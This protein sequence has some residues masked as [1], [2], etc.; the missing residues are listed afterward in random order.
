MYFCKFSTKTFGWYSW[1]NTK[2]KEGVNVGIA[3][4]KYT[5]LIRFSVNHV[6]LLYRFQ[7]YSGLP[8]H[9]FSVCLL[10]CYSAV[11]LI[12]NFSHYLN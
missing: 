9:L 2:S 5:I 3:N 11:A 12:F 6:L 4:T 7:G 8:T 1:M 10:H